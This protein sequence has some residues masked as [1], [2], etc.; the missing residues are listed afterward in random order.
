MTNTNRVPVCVY[1]VFYPQPGGEAA[2]MADELFR[3]LRLMG[4]GSDATAMGL[5]IYYR[6][7][8]EW[9][10]RHSTDPM[11]EAED[12]VVVI[13]VDGAMTTS[14]DWR[15]GLRKLCAE[16]KSTPRIHV[17]PVT[18]DKSF[19]QLPFFSEY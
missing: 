19:D 14:K 10:R 18:L 5:P 7:I 4:D 8:F 11:E 3:W 12:N 2:H 6:S 13:L 17:L 9:Q 15:D 16:A 1:T